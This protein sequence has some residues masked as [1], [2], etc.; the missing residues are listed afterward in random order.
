LLRYD[1][2]AQSLAGLAQMQSEPQMLAGVALGRALSDYAKG[3]VR[4]A[5]TVEEN[6]A[7]LKAVSLDDV[8]QGQFLYLEGTT[9]FSFRFDNLANPLI[10]VRRMVNPLSSNAP[11]VRAYFVSTLLFD[12]L[13]LTNPSASEEVRIKVCVVGDL[14]ALPVC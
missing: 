2:G 10:P 14:T 7:D 12:A 6:I 13:W 11:N 3:D 4:Y 8:A 5:R 1:F 9:D